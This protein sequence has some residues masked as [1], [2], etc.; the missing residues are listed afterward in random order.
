MLVTDAMC[1]AGWVVGTLSRYFRDDGI[2]VEMYFS[3]DVIEG[4]PFGASAA[5]CRASC[6]GPG[7][8]REDLLR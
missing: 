7:S 3:A 4:L 6:S 5:A 1:D 8:S 2:V